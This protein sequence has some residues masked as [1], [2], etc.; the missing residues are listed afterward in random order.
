VALALLA[1]CGEKVA[2]SEAARKLGEQPKQ[3]VDKAAADLKKG[4]ER[5]VERREETEP[6]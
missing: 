5:G 3:V 4:L 1:G 6:K 2:E